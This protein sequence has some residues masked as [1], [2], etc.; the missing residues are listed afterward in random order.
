MKIHIMS[1]VL[2]AA[3][4]GQCI[5]V[6]KKLRAKAPLSHNVTTLVWHRG[7][8]LEGARLN[9]GKVAVLRDRFLASD[10]I[11]FDMPS[12]N[13]SPNGR[14]LAFTGAPGDV[15]FFDAGAYREYL[16][17]TPFNGR[18]RV[19]AAAYGRRAIYEDERPS[20]SFPHFTANG[21]KVV[22][23]ERAIGQF[24][25]DPSPA[26]VS[27][28]DIK[29]RRRTFDSR[30]FVATLP[31]NETQKLLSASLLK[32]AALSPDGNDL[33]CFATPDD[34][35]SLS[36]L[37]TKESVVPPTQLVHLDLRHKRAQILAS[38]D[39]QFSVERMTIT[40]NGSSLDRAIRVLMPQFAWHP[41]Q[42]KFVFAGPVSATDP[43]VNLFIY[44]LNK[45]QMTPFSTGS[46]DDFS[47]QW[48]L[49]GK[50]IFWVRGSTNAQNIS[51]NQIFR[52]N[53]DGSNPARLFPAIKGIT[54]IQ[55]LP[56]IAD[57][58]RYRKLDIKPLA[59]Q[60]K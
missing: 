3:V 12:W 9:G 25:E 56:Q 27:I 26:W 18:P 43:A 42:K 30:T 48:S 32:Y 14:Q 58:T 49:D 35:D 44:D 1:A 59:G 55:L 6:P 13:F 51:D 10:E 22:V 20:Y 39:D 17:L 31:H 52:A 36:E 4:A 46:K 5:A 53:A 54:Q 28:Y 37:Y 34:G 47:P 57:W 50:Q 33:V 21:Q 2:M 19:L 29:T 41:T 38:L 16:F 8:K 15:D 60:D 11:V 40:T 23:D 24:M 7:N 45:R